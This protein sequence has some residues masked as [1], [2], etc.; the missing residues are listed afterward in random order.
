MVRRLEHRERILACTDEHQLFPASD[1]PSVTQAI[2]GGLSSFMDNL[3]SMPGH[4][5]KKK[6]SFLSEIFD[7][8]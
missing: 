4:H 5:D 2:V 8:G 1:R 6:K 7:F 3:R